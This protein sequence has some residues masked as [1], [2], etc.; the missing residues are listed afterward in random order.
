MAYILRSKSVRDKII[1]LAQG[2]SRYNISKIKVMDVSI[3]LP[4]LDEQQKIGNYFR[5]LD[6]LITL[7][8]SKIDQLQHIKKAFL[9]KMF[10]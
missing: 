2:I 8:Q 1:P 5:N 3:F 7:Q 4:S 9:D 10:V 6:N